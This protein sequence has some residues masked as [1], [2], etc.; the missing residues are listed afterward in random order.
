MCGIFENNHSFYDVTRSLFANILTLRISMLTAEGVAFQVRWILCTMEVNL[1][2]RDAM[3]L[4]SKETHV[5]EWECNALRMATGS[6]S[7]KR[8][9]RRSHVINWMNYTHNRNKSIYLYLANL[10][11]LMDMVVLLLLLSLPPRIE[12]DTAACVHAHVGPQ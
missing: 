4:R 2:A 10:Q 12:T 8:N 11:Y 6:N 3:T 5:C 7:I 9:R 1:F